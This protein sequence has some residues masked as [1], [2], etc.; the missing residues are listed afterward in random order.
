[1]NTVQKI[2]GAILATALLAGSAFG[3][4]VWLGERK[5]RRTVAIRVVPVA[6]VK[7]A[8]ALRQGKDL[9]QS[10]GCGDCHGP[11]GHGIVFVDEPG[12][13]RVQAPNISPGPGNVV[14]GYT[15]ADWVRAIRHGVDPN[16]RAL[17]AMPSEEYAGLSDHDFA[18]LVAY[19]RSLPPVAGDAAVIRL[20]A[21]A[22]ALYGVGLVKDA[23]EK[24]D[25]RKPPP[26][27]TATTSSSR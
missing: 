5:L 4:A 2:A 1:L 7:D 11:D 26:A 10:R 8:A 20:P 3:A 14:H 23:A 17:L 21:M 22:K 9:Y 24:I 6:F 16:G 25:H 15:E 19:V 12:G 27:V 18:A 13:R